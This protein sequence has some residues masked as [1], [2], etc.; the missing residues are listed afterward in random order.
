LNTPSYF[1]IIDFIILTILT[2]L[3]FGTFRIFSKALL[4]HFFSDFVHLDIF[5]KW[6][7]MHDISHK[8]NILYA[9]VLA[10][11]GISFMIYTTI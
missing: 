6:D 2:K 8:I 5:R 3:I 9:G 7:K 4:A 1:I 10:V 11:I